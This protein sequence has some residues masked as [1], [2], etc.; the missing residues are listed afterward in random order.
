MNRSIVLRFRAP[1]LVTVVALLV[2]LA[3]P[4]SAMAGTRYVSPAR[5]REALSSSR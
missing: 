1:F 5:V 2:A 3:A 4:G